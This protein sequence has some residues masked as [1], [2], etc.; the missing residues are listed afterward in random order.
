MTS[1]TFEYGLVKFQCRIVNGDK[2]SQLASTFT[3][4]LA[5]NVNIILHKKTICLVAR[6]TA[7]RKVEWETEKYTDAR[8]LLFASNI[9]GILFSK[10]KNYQFET[11]TKMDPGNLSKKFLYTVTAPFAVA[12]TLCNYGIGQS[13]GI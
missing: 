11:L 1:F 9:Y 2:F 6:C 10:N 12:I 7:K 13:I 4:L 8:T 3:H 5:L